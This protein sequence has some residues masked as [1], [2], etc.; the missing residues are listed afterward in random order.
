[1]KGDEPSK[2]GDV[3]PITQSISPLPEEVSTSKPVSKRQR[4]PT[5]ET[6]PNFSRVTAAQMA[7]ISFP[8]EGRY[9]PVRVI[10]AARS[11]SPKGGADKYAG[12]GGIILLVDRTPNEEAEF[13]EFETPAP[14]PPV[15]EA[16]APTAG[17]LPTGPHIALDENAPE[18]GPPASFEVLIIFFRIYSYCSPTFSV[19]F[20][21][22]RCLNKNVVQNTQNIILT[23]LYP[24]PCHAFHRLPKHFC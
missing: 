23:L 15:V 21:Q 8:S 10:T 11:P 17:S 24:V 20:R 16:P 6:L 19:S 3:S 22:R 13:I 12:G 9:Q 4:E 1:M 5:S 2:H 7:Y 18:A 14:P